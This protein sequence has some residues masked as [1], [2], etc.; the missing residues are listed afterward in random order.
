M[1]Q[2][3]GDERGA[4]LVE[5]ALVAPL[6]LL[7]TFG[8]IDAGWAFFQNLEVRHGAREAARLAAVDWGSSAAIIDQTCARMNATGN[9][10]FSVALAHQGAGK[11]GDTAAVTVTRAH[12]SLSG[13]LPF[14]DNLTLQTDVEIR[15][16]QKAS[17]T[18]GTDTC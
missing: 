16:E 12:E 1:S 9:S 3:V 7:L 11:V 6:L 10:D 5:F 17:W 18:D 14:F 8:M 4:A 15:L 13:F 2:G